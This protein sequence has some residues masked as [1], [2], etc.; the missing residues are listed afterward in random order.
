LDIIYFICR[1]WFL[2][3]LNYT[4]T[5]LRVQTEREF[6]RGGTRTINVE[7]Q[8]GTQCPGGITGPPC[9]WGFKYGEIALQV[10]GDSRIG[11]VKYG[12]ESRG[13]QTRE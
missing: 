7:N 13:T 2:Y 12:L 8:A 5:I 9:S 10:G 1:L 3:N 4:S 11:T 6:T